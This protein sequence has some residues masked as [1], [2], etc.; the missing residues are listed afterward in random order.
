MKKTAGFTLLEVLLS[1]TI[2]TLLVGISLP[3]YASFVRR[4]D[5]DIA[6]QDMAASLRRAEAYA[7]AVQGDAVWSV[8]VQSSSFTLY[9]GTDFAARNTAYDETVDLPDTVTPSGLSDVQFAKLTAAPNTT[10]TITLTSTTNDIRTI[11]VNAKGMV[12]Y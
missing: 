10:G 4:N 11:T 3:V 7:R 12:D 6:V 8:R 2:I 1:V 5:L 9:R